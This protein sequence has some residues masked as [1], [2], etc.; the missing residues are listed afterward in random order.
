MEKQQEDSI[1]GISNQG[2]NQ[3]KMENLEAG[4]D[5]KQKSEIN[6]KVS[7]TDEGT[8]IPDPT[9][10]NLWIDICE[11]IANLPISEAKILRASYGFGSLGL[12]AVLVLTS[13]WNGL[14]VDFIQLDLLIGLTFVSSLLLGFA[15]SFVT[16]DNGSQCPECGERFAVRTKL[17]RKTDRTVR[18]NR[19]DIIHGKRERAC[20]NCEFQETRPDTW[21]PDEFDNLQST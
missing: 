14:S 5:I 15:H 4:G 18:E 13:P 6:Q 20:R 16:T 3:N 12:L 9:S 8:V 21:T 2:D 17:V 1:T 7:E 11:T 19:P 10:R